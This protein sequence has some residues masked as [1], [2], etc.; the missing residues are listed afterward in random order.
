M[1]INIIYILI[2]LITPRPDCGAPV[3]EIVRMAPAILKCLTV[4]ISYAAWG[5][6]RRA[7]RKA[8]K[9]AIDLG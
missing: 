8:P 5:D 7:R 3:A 1:T 2:Y 6:R 9:S 4:E